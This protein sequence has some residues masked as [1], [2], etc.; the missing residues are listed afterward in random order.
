MTKHII[1]FSLFALLLFPIFATAQDCS[2]AKRLTEQALNLGTDPATFPQQKELLARAL[3]LCPQSANAHNLLGSVLE[4]EG[5][6]EQALTHYQE[7]ARLK[8]D[9]AAAWFGVGKMYYQT[10]RTST[11]DD[12]RLLDRASKLKRVL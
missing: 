1:L 3:N 5:R 12:S 7:A 2:E 10:G 11:F 6:Y 9:W 4:A 8:P